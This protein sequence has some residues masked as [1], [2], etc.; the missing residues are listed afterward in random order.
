MWAILHD[1]I[2]LELVTWNLFNLFF[3]YLYII[4][5]PLAVIFLVEKKIHTP[6]SA[7][8]ENPI[9]TGPSSKLSTGIIQC[10]L[11]KI[12]CLGFSFNSE[13]C[14]LAEK[15]GALTFIDECHATGFLGDTGR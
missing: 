13:L 8:I 10:S 1:Q 2:L 14:D 6:S 9:Y 5:G 3:I 12:T 7:K 11:T 15:Y 4:F